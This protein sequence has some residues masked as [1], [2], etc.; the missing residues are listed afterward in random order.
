[1]RTIHFLILIE[2]HAGQGPLDEH[3]VNV[4]TSFP[5]PVNYRR[6]LVKS[7]DFLGKSVKVGA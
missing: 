3:L 6:F 4:S 5:L 7:Y 2:L 1:M